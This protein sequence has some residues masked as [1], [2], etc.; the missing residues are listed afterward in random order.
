LPPFVEGRPVEFFIL[1][2]AKADGPRLGRYGDREIP[3]SVID[4]LG[5]R[6]SYDGV[7]PQGERP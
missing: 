6:Y 2:D 4:G 1:H 7:A 3:A 5:R